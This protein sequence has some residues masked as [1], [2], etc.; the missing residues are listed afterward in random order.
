MKLGGE[1]RNTMF[2]DE[3][4]KLL[5]VRTTTSL[6]EVADFEGRKYRTLFLEKHDFYRGDYHSPY[7]DFWLE[8]INA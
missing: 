4:H 7:Y 5:A 6:A 8:D 2:F 1:M 3:N